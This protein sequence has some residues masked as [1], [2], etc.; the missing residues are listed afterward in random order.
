MY[1]ERVRIVSIWL[2]WHSHVVVFFIGKVSIAMDSLL[3]YSSWCR[4]PPPFS[5]QMGDD[6][7]E[8]KTKVVA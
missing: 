7:Y 5:L 2:S 8:W 4:D 1:E 3:V 6:Q